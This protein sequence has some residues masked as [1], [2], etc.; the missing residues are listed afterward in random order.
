MPYADLT[1]R[2]LYPLADL[3]SSQVVDWPAVPGDVVVPAGGTLV[4]WVK[5]GPNDA[6]TAADFNTHFGTALT[7]G[8]DLVEMSVGGMANGSARGLEVGTSTGV[9]FSRAYYNLAGADDVDADRGIQYGSDPADP[10]RRALLRTDVASPGAVTADQRPAAPVQIPADTTAP[11]VTDT[12]PAELD[13]TADAVVAATVTDDVLVR[14]VTLHL[15]S[16]VDDT[17]RVLAL[18]TDGQ[19]GYATTIAA[20]DLT[21]KT[22]YEYWFEASDGTS[23]TRT[24]VVRVPIAGVDTSPVRLSVTGGG[25]VS[26][27]TTVSAAGDTYPAAV[28]L[29]IDGSPVGDVAPALE[30]APQFVVEIAGVNTFFRNGILVGEDVLAVVDD[31]PP[32]GYQTV[33]TAVPLSYVRQGDELVVSVWAGTKAAPEI[34]PDENNDDFTI[35]GLRLVLPDGR[36][37]TPAGYDD[38]TRVLSMGDSAGKLDYYDARFTLPGDAFTAVAHDWDTTAVADGPHTVAATDGTDSAAATVV[39]DNTAPA[40]ATTVGDGVTYRG[41]FTVGATGTDAGSGLA[42]L[43]AT[44]DGAPVTLPLATSSLTLPAGDHRFVVTATDAVG[45]EAVRTVVFTTPVEQPEATLGGPADG[46]AVDGS[47]EL[48]ATVTD[49]SGDVLD[50]E[51]AEGHRLVPGDAGV[52]SSQGVTGIAAGTDRSDAQLLTGADVAALSGVDGLDTGVSSDSAFPYQLFRVAVPAGTEDALARVSWSGSANAEA[53]VLLYVQDAATGGWIEVD[54]YVT[55]DGAATDFELAAL[56][57]VAGHVTDGAIT[58]LV[59]H[60]EG[61]AGADLSTSA[62]PVDPFHPEDTPRSDYDFTLGWESDTQYYNAS[63]PQRQTDIHDY[64]LDRRDELNLQYVFHTGDVVDDAGDPAQWANADPAYRA[65]DE[66]GLPYGVLA[67]NHDVGQMDGDYTEFSRFFGEAR[68]AGNPWYGESY[69]DN[70]GHYDLITA[71][72]M[73]F[74]MLYMGWGPGQAEIDWMNEVLAQYPERTAVINLHEY[75]LTTGGLGPVPQQVYD[76]VVATNPNVAMVFS[77]HYHDAFTRVDEFD[78]D[79]DGAADRS[80]YQVLFDYQGLPEGGQSFLRLLHFSTADQQVLARTFSPYL[81][82]YDSEDP[83]LAPEHQEFT[84]PFAA[85]GLEQRTKTLATDGFAVELLTTSTI[86]TVADVPSGTRVTATWADPGVGTHGWYVRTTDPYGAVDLSEVR[87]FTVAG[88]DPGTG[89]P[90]TG[91]PG[92]GGPGTGGPGTGGPAG[93]GTGGPTAPGV[94]GAPG[95]P[96]VT[97][98]DGGDGAGGGTAEGSRPGGLASTGSPVALTA[99]LGVLLL[100]GGTALLTVRRRRTAD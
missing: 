9:P 97:R 52:T 81:M 2:Y 62:T 42:S 44:L 64:F 100:G 78:D 60:S 17:E 67:G 46:A 39:V 37:L 73:D 30:S 32:T 58:V 95:G 86:A 75:M 41:D 20:A 72:G 92:T 48:S 40:V 99:L 35:R 54:R 96:G 57:P 24:D 38:P 11:V 25:F 55:T 22:F 1:L 80:V 61:F 36:T 16:D 53:K 85:I 27:T 28:Q 18:T 43:E 79:G 45:N 29:S 7:A 12:T 14:R 84:I 47:A 26:G 6:L 56:V 23:T 83:T 15:R 93:P 21:G 89:G 49:P 71:G 65:L 4:L 94:P 70:R 74:L 66:A 8:V 98:P 13:P 87:L 59:Q 31:G 33:S 63:Y 88:A 10:L 34:D 5:N 77:G 51:F 82:Q 50:V 19:A 76:E 91:G 68:F 90:G 69:Q 3:T